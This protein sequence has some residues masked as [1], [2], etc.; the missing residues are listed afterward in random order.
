[1][2][3]RMM[4]LARRE[5]ADEILALY[6]AIIA[7]GRTTW[8]EYYP[9]ME[10]IEFDLDADGLYVLRQD[11]RIAA[12]VSLVE[13][14]DLDDEPMD[15]TEG[16]TCALARLGVRPDLQRQGIGEW[17]ARS[18]MKRA[19]ELGFEWMRLLVAT[20]S[21]SAERIYQRIGYRKTGETE[22]YGN[23][24]YAYECKIER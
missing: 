7:T 22:M 24:Y 5:D 10:D 15:W 4:E 20:T 1:M 3:E 11:G 13:H 23:R 17:M 16:K 2:E 14:D 19:G 18:A 9:S 12:A 6:Q 21:G 8:N